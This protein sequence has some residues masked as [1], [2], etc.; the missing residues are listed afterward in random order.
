MAHEIYKI[1]TLNGRPKGS[2][3]FDPDSETFK[4]VFLRSMSFTRPEEKAY[5]LGTVQKYNDGS[6]TIRPHTAGG[7][8]SKFG[9]L[10]A[11]PER[12]RLAELQGKTLKENPGRKRKRVAKHVR[13]TR[14]TKGLARKSRRSTGSRIKS[15]PVPIA[16]GSTRGTRRRA[17]RPRRRHVAVRNPAHEHVVECYKPKGHKFYYYQDDERLTTNRNDAAR[18]RDRIHALAK[19]KYIRDRV[20]RGIAWVRVCPA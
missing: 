20:P 16:G 11:V 9:T 2:I 4:T 10:V 8:V 19:A 6:F 5:Q 12:G 14:K 13:R 17:G 18:F 7:R 15:I 1:E 3:K